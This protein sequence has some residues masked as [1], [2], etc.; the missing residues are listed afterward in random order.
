MADTRRQHIARQII[1]RLTIGKDQ[2]MLRLSY[3][4]MLEVLDAGEAG[5][6]SDA[7][8]AESGYQPSVM[9][10]EGYLEITIAARF[11]DM[12]KR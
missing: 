8:Q 4:G 9:Q 12:L 2:L 5:T 10:G 1:E 6:I 11:I 7:E 3:A